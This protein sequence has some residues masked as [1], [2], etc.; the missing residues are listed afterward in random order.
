M[1]ED[2]QPAAHQG[3]AEHDRRRAADIA[4]DGAVGGARQEIKTMQDYIRRVAKML[5]K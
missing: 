3:Q 1:E 4:V 5:I 2:I